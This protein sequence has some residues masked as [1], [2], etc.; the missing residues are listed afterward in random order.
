MSDPKTR[1]ATHS[2]RASPDAG[3]ALTPRV[4]QNSVYEMI[5]VSYPC[6]VFVDKPYQSNIF[7]K[8]ETFLIESINSW[9]GGSNSGGGGL[10]SKDPI[11]SSASLVV[12]GSAVVV[13]PAAMATIL[14][15]LSSF[16]R[17]VLASAAAAV[18]RAIAA[19]IAP[20]LELLQPQLRQLQLP[21]C[22]ARSQTWRLL[23]P[24]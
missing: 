13:V 4:A 17:A 3:R 15:W 18:S 14:A 10:N 6:P 7:T 20:S 8:Y 11:G 12:L 22:A 24:E 5:A 19:S 23:A 1:P 9:G 21:L 2:A 16:S